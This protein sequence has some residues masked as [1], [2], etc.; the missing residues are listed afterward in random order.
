MHCLHSIN[1]SRSYKYQ[2]NV[3][4]AWGWQR[5][6]KHIPNKHREVLC[7][8]GS[9]FHRIPWRVRA[10]VKRV[11]SGERPRAYLTYCTSLKATAAFDQW[12]ERMTK[13]AFSKARSSASEECLWL[14]GMCGN[15]GVKLTHLWSCISAVSPVLWS[16]YT[17]EQVNSRSSKP[18][19]QQHRGVRPELNAR[20]RAW[21]APREVSRTALRC[22]GLCHKDENV[23]AEHLEI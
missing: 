2:E 21:F 23:D 13:E 4:E 18:L 20:T 10:N 5:W 15:P 17:E 8:S 1:I 6:V 22:S 19:Q 3:G 14:V 9:F 11:M 16:E 7:F 12:K